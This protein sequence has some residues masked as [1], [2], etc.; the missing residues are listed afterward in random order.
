MATFHHINANKPEFDNGNPP[1]LEKLLKI[2][3]KIKAHFL[4]GTLLLLQYYFASSI[5]EEIS[6]ILHTISISVWTY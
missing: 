6:K 4:H 5:I 2:G 3:S 1:D